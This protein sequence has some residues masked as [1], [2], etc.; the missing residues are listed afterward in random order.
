MDIIEKFLEENNNGKQRLST[1]F[2]SFEKEIVQ[3][4]YS[5]LNPLTIQTFQTYWTNIVR[6]QIFSKRLVMDINL[7]D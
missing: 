5:T 3:M 7:I 6:N 1:C 2:L 4:D